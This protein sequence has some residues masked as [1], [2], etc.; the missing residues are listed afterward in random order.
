VKQYYSNGTITFVPSNV[1][2]IAA[3]RECMYR[4]AKRGQMKTRALLY[5]WKKEKQT[6]ISKVIAFD[7][8]CVG[9][10]WHICL[11]Q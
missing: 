10:C 3:A 4:E 9:F 1:N 2:F 11:H 8:L 7:T 5:Q 6:N